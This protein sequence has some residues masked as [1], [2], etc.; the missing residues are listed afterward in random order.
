ME[1]TWKLIKDIDF[2]FTPKYFI[3]SNVYCCWHFIFK[4][5]PG[6]SGLVF[7]CA[8]T[9]GNQVV[10]IKYQKTLCENHISTRS[11]CCGKFNNKVSSKEAEFNYSFGIYSIEDSP[12]DKNAR[13]VT[14]PAL[15]IPS[16]LHTLRRD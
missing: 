10:K 16:H 12:K 4:R 2:C 13:E 7:C 5:D 3:G 14:F 8:D 6:I 11:T 15:R 1:M 9:D